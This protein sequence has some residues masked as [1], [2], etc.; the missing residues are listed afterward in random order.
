MELYIISGLTI[1]IFTFLT[2]LCVQ[3]IRIEKS[4]TNLSFIVENKV[5]RLLHPEK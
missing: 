4:I 3:L 1:I 5:K 2:S